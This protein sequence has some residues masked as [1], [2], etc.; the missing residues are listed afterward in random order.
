LPVEPSL[1]GLVGTLDFP[2]GL[3]VVC[4][5]VVEPG[6]LPMQARASPPSISAVDDVDVDRRIHVEMPCNPKQAA[7][8]RTL[9]N[10][11]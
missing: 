5:G 10:G 8:G 11:P 2:A 6:L 4:A 9:H 7:T 3:R 1:Q